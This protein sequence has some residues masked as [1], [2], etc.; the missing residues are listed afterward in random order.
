[1]PRCIL[2]LGATAML[3]CLA[4]CQLPRGGNQLSQFSKN[5]EHSIDATGVKTLT[6]K[7]GSGSLKVIGEEGR[8]SI[9]LDGVL[10]A[11]AETIDE[12][13]RI[14]GE[15]SLDVRSE[16][17]ENPEIRI[18]EP[19]LARKGQE[20]ALDLVLRVPSTVRVVI[21]DTD[22]DIDVR[23]LSNGVRVQSQL[24]AVTIAEC[25]GG[26]ELTTQGVSASITDS[27]GRI[28]VVDGRGD[29]EIQGITGDIEVLDEN[30]KLTI[31][32][33]SGNVTASDNPTPVTVQNVQG[34]VKLI[35]IDHATA[36]VEGIGGTL[37]YPQT[38]R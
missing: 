4:S 31:R 38:P 37:S 6:L 7:T 26:V 29:L 17:T 5:Y 27:S 11:L 24:G 19:R 16:N 32:H 23:T 35:R 14:A 25:R 2:A 20:Y 18:L 13:R 33:V 15:I 28:Q 3:L 12:A 34:D 36:N 30:G 9:E 21:D 10:I 22:G 8:R 1:M